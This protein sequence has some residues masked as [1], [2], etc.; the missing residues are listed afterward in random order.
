[1][2]ELAQALYRFKLDCQNQTTGSIPS[3][4]R[5]DRF[6]IWNSAHTAIRR[7]CTGVV[8]VKTTAKTEQQVQ[9]SVSE[10]LIDSRERWQSEWYTWLQTFLCGEEERRCL[11]CSILNTTQ[12][13]TGWGPGANREGQG[14]DQA[15]HDPSL[16]SEAPDIIYSKG[17]VKQLNF[18]LFFNY[19]ICLGLHSKSCLDRQH[20]VTNLI[21]VTDSGAALGLQFTCRLEHDSDKM[22]WKFNLYSVLS[23][24]GIPNMQE[25]IKRSNIMNSRCQT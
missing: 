1:M 22:S 4:W 18:I 13:L 14:H 16:A 6:S 9:Y 8:T 24:T 3:L 12:T 5:I 2:E 10:E 7:T 25:H 23:I 17:N 19:V 21:A 15:C 20:N 11:K